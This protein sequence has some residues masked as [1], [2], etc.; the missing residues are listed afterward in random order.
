[1]K[2]TI[3]TSDFSLL[4]V[5]LRMRRWTSLTVQWL[6]LLVSTAGVGVRSLVGEPEFPHA[7]QSKSKYNNSFKKE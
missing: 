4:Y 2:M 1:M 5:Q 3:R 6:R 7:G